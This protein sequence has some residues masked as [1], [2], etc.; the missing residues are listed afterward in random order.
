MEL[1]RWDFSFMPSDAASN[2][3]RVK[4]F[5]T[6]SPRSSAYDEGLFAVA[7]HIDDVQVR[8]TGR[9]AASS[10]PDSGHDCGQKRRTAPYG[11]HERES[12]VRFSA[13]STW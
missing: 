12:V 11:A 2:G 9:A 8:P 5:L 1:S 3:P 10:R 6:A 4:V 13:C 7:R